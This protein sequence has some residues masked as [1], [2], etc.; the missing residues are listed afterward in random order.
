MSGLCSK[1][2]YFMKDYFRSQTF[3]NE[4]YDIV[5][6]ALE[7][8][9]ALKP[10]IHFDTTADIFVSCMEAVFQIVDGYERSDDNTLKAVR[11]G[12]I[13]TIS[14][15]LKLRY[16]LEDLSKIEDNHDTRALI[17]GHNLDLMTSHTNVESSMAV[18][19]FF[20]EFF[21]KDAESRAYNESFDSLKLVPR[22]TDNKSKHNFLIATLKSKAL[23]TL[24][25]LTN[26]GEEMTPFMY[27]MFYAE[28]DPHAL[29]VNVAYQRE[30]F[31]YYH[32]EKY[33]VRLLNLGD[34]GT[35]SITDSFFIIEIGYLVFMFLIKL[36]QYTNDKIPDPM[37]NSKLLAIM[38]LEERQDV[39]IE[40]MITTQ[41]ANLYMDI[42]KRTKRAIFS[43]KP[44]SYQKVIK[45]SQDDAKVEKDMK[46]Y[47]DTTSE[48]DI[49]FEDKIVTYIFPLL[50]YCRLSSNKQ[51][52]EFM[53]QID[54]SSAQAKCS[55]LFEESKYLIKQMKIHYWM[56]NNNTEIGKVLIKYTS[57]WISLFKIYIIALNLIMLA[58]Y[59]ESNGSREEDP[60]L[61]GLSVT[62]TKVI[63]FILGLLCGIM[64]L[65]SSIPSLVTLFWMAYY[66][67]EIED[68]LAKKDTSDPRLLSV[69]HS[70]KRKLISTNYKILTSPMLYYTLLLGVSIVLGLALHP[71]FYAFLVTYLIV[72]SPQMN[73]LLRAIWEPRLAIIA[74]IVLMFLIVYVLVVVSYQLLYSYYPENS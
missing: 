17:V 4:S 10:Y 59:S 6:A 65:L 45:N 71:F 74:T 68:D 52:E 31:K 70:R 7:Y 63:M 47:A 29:R 66:R 62:G 21:S 32:Q 2:N 36:R 8:Y 23:E 55:S 19:R 42:Y 24:L 72:E 56:Q 30:L 27:N 13:S 12:I 9:E 50:P 22:I 5:Q 58:S 73:S 44:V 46:F 25:E 33:R 16:Y 28:L 18:S 53:H 57:L 39:E 51:K 26:T 1:L 69:S 20:R 48:I 11:S 38:P 40:G 37:Y 14:N 61:F 41:M 35:E 43:P 49:Y 67:A 34:L 15:V 60:M 64:W 54:R 3:S